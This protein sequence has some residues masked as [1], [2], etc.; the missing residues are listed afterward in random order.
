M[1]ADFR[2]LA[3][4]ELAGHGDIFPEAGMR[5]MAFGAAAG[6]RIEE[7]GWRGIMAEP[8]AG[9]G[10]RREAAHAL[11]LEDEIADRVED[12]LAFVDFHAERRMRSVA[13]E[14]IGAGIDTLPR[15]GRHEIRRLLEVNLGCRR[16][17]ALMRELVAVET[18]QHP[19]GLAPRF[20]DPA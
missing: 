14:D 19:I 9:I 17:N 4:L 20:L 3:V 10:L 11:V 16:G 8:E 18:H 7:V 6:A 5:D 15:E 12:R 1:D 13:D 2:G